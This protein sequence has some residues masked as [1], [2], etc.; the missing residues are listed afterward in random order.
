MIVIMGMMT[1]L[2]PEMLT[3][4]SIDPPC[5]CFALLVRALTR[6]TASHKEPLMPQD[7]MP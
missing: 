7:P 4:A 5:D 3:F 6:R 2:H 1:E